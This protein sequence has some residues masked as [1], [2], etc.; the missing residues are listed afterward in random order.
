MPARLAGE[1]VSGMLDV[2]ECEWA[3]MESADS[4]TVR[5]SE[6]GVEYETGGGCTWG[7]GAGVMDMDIGLV[8]DVGVSTG[9][10]SL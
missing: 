7:F 8:V 2:E 4:E 6:D 1:G 3:E 5:E 10:Y 9:R